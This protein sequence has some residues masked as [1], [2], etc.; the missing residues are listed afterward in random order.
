MTPKWKVDRLWYQCQKCGAPIGLLGRFVQWVGLSTHKCPVT[1]DD[2]DDV[3][4]HVW[5][6]PE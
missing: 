6:L 1:L 2:V 3:R 5:K 4:G